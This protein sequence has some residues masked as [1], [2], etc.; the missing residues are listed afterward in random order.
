MD[1]N[2]LLIEPVWNRNFFFCTIISAAFTFNRTSMESKLIFNDATLAINNLLIEPVWNRNLYLR[3]P[4][5]SRLRAFNR[6]S[7][8][9]KLRT[10][11]VLFQDVP[12]L[13]E[14][15]WNRNY[16]IE[17][18]IRLFCWLLIEPVWNRNTRASTKRARLSTFNRTSM[19]SKH[20]FKEMMEEMEHNF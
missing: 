19:E 15:V 13:I 16:F 18:R 17:I 8:E 3:I 9:S 6:T 14:P 12:L 7:M 10:N 20:W 5:V 11:P 1:A 2:M 4:V